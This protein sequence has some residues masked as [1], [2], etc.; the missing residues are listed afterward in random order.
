MD[1]NI[2]LEHLEKNVQKLQATE[3]RLRRVEALC[4]LLVLSTVFL[5][6]AWLGS[7]GDRSSAMA[8]SASVDGGSV[9]VSIINASQSGSRSGTV[10]IRSSQVANSTFV[11]TDGST[12]DAE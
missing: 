7:S 2:R 1:E 11:A 4:G 3:A 12:I 6:W 8:G 10:N 9:Q 5:A